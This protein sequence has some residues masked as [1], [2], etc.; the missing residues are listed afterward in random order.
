ML[1]TTIDYLGR[2]YERMPI[3]LYVSLILFFFISCCIIT[4]KKGVIEGLRISSIVLL[5]EYVILIFCSTV[6]FRST[7]SEAMFDMTPFRTYDDYQRSGDFY[8]SEVLMNIAVFT[9][10]G[11]LA[12][13][14]CRYI[15]WW[16]VLTIGLTL[17]VSI[18]L[19]QF[20]LKRG[21]CELDDILAN[22][23]GCMVGFGLALIVS[24]I[25]KG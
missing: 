20:F 17:S 16:R 25:N 12:Y 10:V 9:P 8:L 2:L 15:Q 11:F 22:A 1:Q 5:I 18:E 7:N 13:W 14:G 3:F 4:L 21:F 6:I 24:K 19:L 23:L